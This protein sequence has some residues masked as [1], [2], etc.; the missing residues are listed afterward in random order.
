MGALPLF[1]GEPHG[2][3][4]KPEEYELYFEDLNPRSKA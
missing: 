4:F 2:L 3:G 1:Q